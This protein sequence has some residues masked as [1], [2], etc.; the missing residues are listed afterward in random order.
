MAKKEAA[1]PAKAKQKGRAKMPV[2]MM[3]LVSILLIVVIKTAYIFLLCGILPSVAAY[4]TD[5]APG[6]HAFQTVLACNL[7]GVAPFLGKILG[8]GVSATALL[9]D[10]TVWF[11]MY[12]AAGMG[13]VLVWLS[14]YLAR[15]IL[16]GYYL[17]EVMQREAA[18]RKLLEE[19]G[20]EIKR[21]EL[22]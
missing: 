18:Q 21:R 2:A 9:S 1:K 14:P 15:A 19:W 10:V 3:V 13:W 12:S 20:P 11:A 16:S 6:R 7:A 4:I 22:G 17:K 8:Q 5:R